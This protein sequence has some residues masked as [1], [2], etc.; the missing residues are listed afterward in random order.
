MAMVPV[1]AASAMISVSAAAED[2]KAV[3]NKQTKQSFKKIEKVK[4]KS[5]W[6]FELK[7]SVM[8]YVI[9]NDK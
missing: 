6:C 8:M 2:R 5:L 1:H 3:N 7:T 9:F 4:N